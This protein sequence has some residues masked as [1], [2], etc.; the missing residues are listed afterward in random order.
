MDETRSLRP[1]SLSAVLL[2]ATLVGPARADRIL[3]KDGSQ[4]RGKAIVDAAHPDQYRVVAES[5]KTPVLLKLDRVLRIDPEPSILDEYAPKRTALGATPSSADEFAL[6]DWCDA[7]GLPDLANFHYEAIARRDPT[8]A[9]ARERLGHTQRDGKWL[10]PDERKAAQGLT[11]YRGR[12][13]TPEEKERVDADSA[14]T[15]EQANWNRQVSILRQSLGSDARGREAEGQLLAIRDPSATR[16]VARILGRDPEPGVRVLAARVLGRIP[17][18][19]ASAALV[20]R[21]LEEADDEVRRETMTELA[22]SPEANVVPKLILALKSK[23]LAVINRAAWALGNLKA[24]AAIPKLIPVLVTTETRLIWEPSTPAANPGYGSIGPAPGYNSGYTGGGISIP[25]LTGPTV[26]PGVVAYGA[27]SVPASSLGGFGGS[28]LSI[29]G[30][31][32]DR[33]PTPRY[34]NVNHPNTEVRNALARLTGKD[35]GFDAASWRRWVATSFQPE[36][37]PIRRVP[38]P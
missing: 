1:L 16:A 23:D 7:H 14:A 31:T 27:T 25:V 22:G 29:G 38:Q 8:F 33:G 17:G 21:L 19:I 34:I 32:V 6:A 20:A 37:A 36:P 3:L 24:L 26:G 12:W 13:I 18:P 10:T 35:F 4:V 9:P 15:A 2:V 28:N 30:G 5:G 11:L